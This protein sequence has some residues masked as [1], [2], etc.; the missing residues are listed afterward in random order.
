MMAEKNKK[1]LTPLE[2]ELVKS[3]KKVQEYKLACEANIVASLF[4]NPDL[5][6]TY[7]KLNIKSFTDNI[8]RVFFAIGYDIIVKENK[9]ERKA[10]ILLQVHDE[11]L[12]EVEESS[13]RELAG[14][15][16]K[17]MEEIWPAS[18]KLQRGEQVG[19]PIVVDVKAGKNWA[20]LK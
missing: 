17:I 8:W 1:E 6:F 10:R 7:D 12:C 9:L 20:S 4:K 16:K 3:S 15:F 2:V 5:Y 11:L 13:V 19:M 14:K 18:Q